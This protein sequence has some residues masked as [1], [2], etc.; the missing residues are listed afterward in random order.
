[1]SS[2]LLDVASEDAEEGGF[3]REYFFGAHGHTA[4]GITPVPRVPV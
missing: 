3:A 1:M 4:V 2:L